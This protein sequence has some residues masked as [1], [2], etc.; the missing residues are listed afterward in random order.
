MKVSFPGFQSIFARFVGLTEF[1]EMDQ[2]KALEAWVMAL[3][4]WLGYPP[5]VLQLVGNTPISKKFKK[6]FPEVFDPGFNQEEYYRKI[7]QLTDEFNGI[8]PETKRAQISLVK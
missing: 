6:V 3:L 1:H 5:E 4:K 2:P 8:T 7:N